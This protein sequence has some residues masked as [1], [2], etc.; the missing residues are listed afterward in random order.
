MAVEYRPVLEEEIPATV[1]LFLASVTDMFARTGVQA[2]PPPRPMV[3][4]NYRHIYRTGIF[5]VA[6]V[7]GRIAAIGHAVVR[8]HLWFL[9][10]FWVQPGMQ[11]RGIGGPLLKRVW[12]EGERKGARKF[13]TW[14]SVDIQAMA[15]YMKMGMLPGYQLLTL[16]GRPGSMP[17]DKASVEV[18]P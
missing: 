4:T 6:T 17:E 14:S 16:A 12:Q 15:S 8:D 11:G 2:P 18:R 10:G 1:E 7:D 13:F 9:S 3:E 5:D